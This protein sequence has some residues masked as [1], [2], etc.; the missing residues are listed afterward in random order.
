MS[1]IDPTQLEEFLRRS[2]MLDSDGLVRFIN[3][4]IVTGRIITPSY[5]SQPVNYAG[6]TNLCPNSD[7]AW[8]Q[9]AATTAGITPGT[10]GDTNHEIHRVWRQV[11]GANI[12]TTRVRG[13]SHSLY[14]ANEGADSSIPIWDRV[15]GTIKMGWAGGGGSDYD[16]AIELNNNWVVPARTMYVRAALATDGSTALPV[17]ARFYAGFWVQLSGG[18][19]GWATGDNYLLSYSIEGIPG[20]RALKY[21]CVAKTDSGTEMHSAVLDV[22]DAPA[23]LSV[24]NRI[25]ISFSGAAG[26]TE[27]LL[28]R[29]DVASGQIDLIARDRNSTQL[30]AYDTGQ[31]IRPVE[32]FP[33]PSVI[34]T[35]AYAEVSPEAQNIAITKTFN[36][37]NIRVPPTF[38][39]SQVV[40]TYLR[41]GL[42][43][44][45]AAD[46]QLIVDT[47]WAGTSYNQ[48]APSP[49]DNYPS[50]PSTAMVTAPPTSG[51]TTG[52]PPNPGG[53]STC[54]DITH[55]VYTDDDYWREIQH[56]RPGLLVDSG[57]DGK[58]N[59][60]LSIISGE[61]SQWFVVTF[62]HGLVL[63]ATG[64]HRFVRAL[65]DA[66]G[67]LVGDLKPG[68]RL[69]GGSP[70]GDEMVTVRSVVIQHGWLEVGT[71]EHAPDSPN[72]LYKSGSART[73]RY[74]YSHNLKPVDIIVV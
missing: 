65:D 43:M 33:S 55:D 29:E 20:T 15:Q 63:R 27:F 31:S 22:L 26:F 41:M 40:K 3:D 57:I 24:D 72:R 16:I 61:V 19:E 68:D 13:S 46:R 4:A 38:D 49:F 18:S 11:R 44:P 62:S 1:V 32:A 8:S 52:N 73:G 70:D 74:V 28:Y 51:G 2:Q 6:G 37:L 71:L 50:P 10:A 59:R 9:M 58:P 30:W 12:G 69:L 64:S 48:W 34:A 7:F 39:T 25:R 14:A 35:R 36:N 54:L 60:V 21:Y 5:Q 45:A 53:G 23:T 56:M 17:G 66:C 42:T 67:L 47:I